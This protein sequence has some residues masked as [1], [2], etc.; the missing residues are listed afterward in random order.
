MG[1]ETKRCGGCRQAKERVDFSRNA[2]TRDGLHNYC[3]ACRADNRAQAYARGGW[4][5]E[6]A[7]NEKKALKPGAAAAYNRKRRLSRQKRRL[8]EYAAAMLP[9]AV[10]REVERALTAPGS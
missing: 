3:R 9:D 1:I 5:K 4:K 8:L 6:R 7:R 2:G 10:F